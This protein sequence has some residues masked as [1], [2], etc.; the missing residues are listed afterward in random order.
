M[1]NSETDMAKKKLTVA[2]ARAVNAVKN[3]IVVKLDG[4]GA[5]CAEW[6]NGVF[7]TANEALYGLLAECKHI[8]DTQFIDASDEVKVALRKELI[9]R[10]TVNERLFKI[11]R[12][13]HQ[14][15]IG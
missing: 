13:F 15:F 8:Y 12:L 1:L 3:D 11:G 4:L 6:E 9:K 10:L 5:K 14:L 2:T 7:K